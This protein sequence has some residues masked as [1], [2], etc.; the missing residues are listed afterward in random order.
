LHL[1]PGQRRRRGVG[2]DH[3]LLV[4]VDDEHGR[5]RVVQ[6]LRQPRRFGRG[7]SDRRATQ[8][9]FSLELVLQLSAAA[10]RGGEVQ[11]E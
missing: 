9:R 2:V 6:Y 3:L 7:C 8:H 5:G 10:E 11:V 4:E 1:L